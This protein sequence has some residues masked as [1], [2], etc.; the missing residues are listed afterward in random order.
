MRFDGVEA[1]CL[2]LDDTLVDARESWHRGFAEATA[3]LRERAPAF[4]ARGSPSDIYEGHLRPLILAAQR[5][6][7][8]SEWS[9]DFARAGFRALLAET[10]GLDGPAADSVCEAYLDAWPRHLRLFDDV[11]PALEA[12]RRRYRLALV[13]NGLGSDQRLKLARLGLDPHFEVIAISEELGVTKPEPAIF[14]HTLE[15]L[16]VTP[17]AAIHVGDNPH[18]DIAGARAA[19]MRGVWLR[20]SGGRFEGPAEADAEVRHLG[21]LVEL[22]GARAE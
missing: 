13:S 6:A 2:D 22:L 9:N 12:L 17:S 14:E 1:V 10:A 11:A 20:R 21:E 3:E 15:R 19:G 5:A 18:H 16:G 8:S 7:G 4:A